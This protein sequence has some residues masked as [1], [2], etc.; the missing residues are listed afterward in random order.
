MPDTEKTDQKPA[1]A[2][3]GNFISKITKK[4]NDAENILVT[5]SRDPSIDE[6][7]AALGL[8]L[9]LDKI[10]KHATAIYS[11][12]TPNILQFLKPEETFEADTN[13]LQDFIVA[14]DKSKADH[15][16]YSV[17]GDY[18]K[19]FITPYKTTIDK[20][21]LEFS[22][23]DYNVDLVIALNVATPND[24]DAA[25]TEHGRI[26]HDAS[27]ID[28]TTGEPGKFGE[29][30][31]SDPVAS[32]VSEMSAELVLSIQEQKSPM[33]EGSATAFLT[34]IIA[35]TER[36]SNAKTT[37]KTMSISSELMKLG[38]DQQ[39]VSSH[40]EEGV[41]IIEN[42]NNTIVDDSNDDP[43]KLTIEHNKD[44][45]EPAPQAESQPE[46][47]A[48]Q[49]AEKPNLVPSPEMQ[50]QAQANPAPQQPQ[51]VPEPQP[52]PA[53]EPAP[54]PVAP[55]PEPQPA[56]VSEPQAAPEPQLTGA[57]DMPPVSGESATISEALNDVTPP[58]G[59][60]SSTSMIAPDQ[61][62]LEVPVENE[63]D[64]GK[65]IDEALAETTA[66]GEGPVEPTQPLVTNMAA[67]AAPPV[68]NQPEAN[69]VPDMNYNQVPPAPEQSVPQPVP[70]PNV[71]TLPPPPPPPMPPMPDGTNA[72][73]QPTPESQA[74]QQPQPAP[75]QPQPAPEPQPQP[76][77]PQAAAQPQ[78]E[79]Q[80]MN[81]PT[82]A[83][84]MFQIPGVQYNVTM[85][86][87]ILLIDKPSGMSSFGVVARVRRILSQEAG[88]KI[89]VG[90]A[91]T[92]DPFATGLLILLIGKG[93]KRATEFLKLDKWYEATIC[94]GKT[95]TTGDPEGEIRTFEI[96]SRDHPEATAEVERATPVTTGCR[97]AYPEMLLSKVLS[98][99]T[100]RIHQR[101]P[102]YSAVKIKGQRAYKLAREGKEVEMPTREVEIY[103][104][105]LVDYKWPYL[106]IRCHVS[107]G[108]YIR[109]L[110]EDIGK[111]LGVGGYLIELRRTQI[112]DFKI[113]DAIPLDEWMKNRG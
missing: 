52:A 16:R 91:G 4:I 82:P 71:E 3:N 47:Q 106:K 34:G 87:E 95:S 83:P 39:L 20:S 102:N 105:D 51:P 81:V 111:A 86:S 23:G 29:I 10:G 13:S 15:L 2:S 90:H 89:K 50:A 54:E 65:M 18:V 26:M 64:Y 45:E 75:E 1:P 37:P 36:F 42:T 104:L 73:P 41:G 57:V 67:S 107:S 32:S 103:Q 40:L 56:P 62:P 112:G 28:I 98:K 97:D 49:E 110:G 27:A 109:T 25:L 79:Q 76:Q 58:A 93:T 12:R 55:V 19:I 59:A 113:Q 94:L 70:M 11:G 21:D 99:F 80:A 61:R 72:A 31:W 44:E 92:L 74:Q 14:L 43:T 24:L 88:H 85:S 78:P 69:S 9:F 5:L 8:T 30:E 63:K 66:Q 33:G 101:V 53:P 60:M 17:D 84:G 96:V 77:Q 22:H 48:P 6:I 108:T 100:G 46:A 7:T 68:M 35:E 38:A